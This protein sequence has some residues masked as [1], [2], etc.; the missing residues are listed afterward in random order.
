MPLCA[1]TIT[2][3]PDAEHCDQCVAPVPW[4]PLTHRSFVGTRWIRPVPV[5]GRI[6]CAACKAAGDLGELEARVSARLKKWGVP[7]K[8]RSFRWTNTIRQGRGEPF[9]AFKG[10]IEDDRTEPIGITHSNAD[11]ARTLRNWRPRKG[12]RWLLV[13]GPTGTGKTLFACATVATLAA[14]ERRIEAVPLAELY[15]RDPG[16]ARLCDPELD[17]AKCF[18]QASKSTPYAR[19]V[20]VVGGAAVSFVQELELQGEARAWY[21][22]LRQGARGEADPVE[23]LRVVPCLVLDD[24]GTADQSD[25]WRS[26][27]E[28]LL[29]YRY[30]HELPTVITSN[31]SRQAIEVAYGARLGSR[32]FEIADYF[33]LE[34]QDWR[35]VGGRR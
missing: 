16:L 22:R 18:P 14:D 23:A 24:L 21:Q 33:E 2:E 31:S 13:S 20:R 19:P 34:L 32:L 7:L 3:Q 4:S 25:R 9:A 12:G 30:S 35:R 29:S 5:D 26:Q 15:E 8:Y 17:T 28:G 11:I 27:I 10:R 1:P 6:L